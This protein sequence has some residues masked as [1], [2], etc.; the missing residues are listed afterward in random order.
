MLRPPPH[1]QAFEAQEYAQAK[2][3]EQASQQDLPECRSDRATAPQA[4]HRQSIN[5][6]VE[7]PAPVFTPA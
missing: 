1:A 3:G 4:K 6:C 7:P 2:Q 5:E